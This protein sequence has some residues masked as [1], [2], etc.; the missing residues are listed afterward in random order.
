MKP[1]FLESLKLLVVSIWLKAL[2]LILFCFNK[3]LFPFKIK[4]PK[5]IIIYKIGNIGDIVCAIPSFTAIKKKFPNSKITLLTS[6]G[7]RGSIG[8]RDFLE[9]APYFDE[10]ITYYSDE[11]SSFSL[12]IKL[13]KKLRAK[14]Y[15][16]FIQ[17]PDDLAFFRTMIRNELFSKFIGSKHAF[18][19]SL[20]TSQL[21]KKTQVDF[22]T[23]DTESVALLKILENNG[24]KSDKIVYE[25]PN[26]A[27]SK[28]IQKEIE[29][30]KNQN[31]L[32]LG[33]CMGGKT[34]GQRWPKDNFLKV[35]NALSVKHK[36][37]VIYFSGAADFEKIN[38]I[39]KGTNVSG[40]N[41]SDKSIKESIIAIKNVD[42]YLTNDTGPMHIAAAHGIPIVALFSIRNIFGSWFPYGKKNICL[43]KNQLECD[44]S[45]I[46][47]EVE[48]LEAIKI[49]EVIVA[50]EQQF[51]SIKK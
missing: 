16:L 46:K 37:G 51:N 20:R 49:E 40:L 36:F 33:V 34:E 22:T 3:I 21:F 31:K 47:C 9:G 8:A 50:C 25:F 5:N 24:I 23:K 38:E 35:I 19:F 18:Q 10:I 39:I 13:I 26:Y 30:F 27:E 48:S 6:P 2:N 42:L 15:D 43:Y 17:L 41:F 7:N 29:S 14:K 45:D 28:N 4:Y 1:S 11:V 44:Y 32:L 12:I